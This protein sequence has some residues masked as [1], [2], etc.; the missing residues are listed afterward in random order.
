MARGISAPAAVPAYALVVT[1]TL[2]DFS[3][4]ELAVS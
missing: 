2:L 1:V 4:G 3:P